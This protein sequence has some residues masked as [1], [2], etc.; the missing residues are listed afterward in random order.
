MRLSAVY[1]FL[2][3]A[4]YGKVLGFR[5]ASPWTSTSLDET[6]LGATRRSFVE[7]FSVATFAGTVALVTTTVQEAA[8]S[9]GATAGGVYLLSVRLQSS[10]CGELKVAV[11]VPES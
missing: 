1:A 10:S 2:L 5:P 9:G 11:M 3:I 7:N 4:V 6:S 8:A